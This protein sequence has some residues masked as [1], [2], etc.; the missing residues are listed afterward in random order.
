MKTPRGPSC[1]RRRLPA[2]LKYALIVIVIPSLLRNR[3]EELDYAEPTAPN[4]MPTAPSKRR[5]GIVWR[6]A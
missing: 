1:S 6:S 3:K 2:L 4:I 5:F